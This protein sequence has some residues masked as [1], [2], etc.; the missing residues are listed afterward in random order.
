MPK[1]VLHELEIRIERLKKFENQ[2]LATEEERRCI[3][4]RRLE[5][6]SIRSFITEKYDKKEK[7]AVNNHEFWRL[8]DD[9]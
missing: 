1:S 2:H 4:S 3:Q 8:V 6:E 9:F 5:L 7:L